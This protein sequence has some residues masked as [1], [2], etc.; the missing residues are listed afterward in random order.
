QIN[1][2]LI[3]EEDDNPEIVFA[4]ND[5]T[6]KTKKLGSSS[7]HTDLKVDKSVNFETTIE[8][9]R[10]KAENFKQ[11]G[12]YKTFFQTDLRN[13]NTFHREFETVTHQRQG[14]EYFY[15][16]IRISL[17]EKYYDVTQLKHN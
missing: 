9:N 3:D 10:F 7:Q 1:A 12:L 4:F 13:I 5:I 15:D 14:I 17:N 16:C 8:L 2:R 6:Y 11:F